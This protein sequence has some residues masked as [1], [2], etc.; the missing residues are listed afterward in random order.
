MRLGQGTGSYNEDKEQ[1]QW[2]DGEK[3]DCRTE[4]SGTLGRLLGTSHST[5]VD[6]SVEEK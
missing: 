4:F 3:R 1:M 5:I 6:S 2:K